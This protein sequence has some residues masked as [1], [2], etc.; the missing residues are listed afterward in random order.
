M[1]YTA[2]REKK[3]SE[4]LQKF[5]DQLIARGPAVGK[6]TVTPRVIARWKRKIQRLKADQKK[7]LKIEAERE[8][9]R[10]ETLR[11]EAELDAEFEAELEAA[12]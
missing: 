4:L 6:E 8:A 7:A 5:I 11:R 1:F 12:A 9:L 2:L 10:L 3:D